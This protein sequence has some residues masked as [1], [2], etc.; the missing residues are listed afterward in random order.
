MQL[1]GIWPQQFAL[2]EKL[3]VAIHKQQGYEDSD[4]KRWLRRYSAEAPNYEEQAKAFLELVQA[5]PA[6]FGPIDRSPENLE[7]IAQLTRAVAMPTG[8]VDEPNHCPPPKLYALQRA[9]WS[10]ETAAGGRT[11]NPEEARHFFSQE[12]A[13]QY[14]KAD[15]AIVEV[16]V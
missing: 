10:Y 16:E 2:G 8:G 13:R 6:I 14:Q 9:D 5:A 7:R 15:Q 12:E 3:Y 4:I 11:D 1:L